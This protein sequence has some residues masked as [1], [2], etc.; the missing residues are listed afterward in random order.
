MEG[1]Q[2]VHDVT[3]ERMAAYALWCA[4]NGVGIIG[5]C[6]G[7]TPRHIEAMARAVERAG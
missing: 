1:G 7:S 2:V 3:P 6:C 4:E 5:G